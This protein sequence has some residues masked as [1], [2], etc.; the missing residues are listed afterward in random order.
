MGHIG[1]GKQETA[2]KEV[3]RWW[4]PRGNTQKGVPRCGGG[5]QD[6]EEY[7]EGDPQGVY[8]DEFDSDCLPFPS[9]S[10]LSDSFSASKMG[11]DV[12]DTVCCIKAKYISFVVAL[13]FILLHIADVIYSV[14]I[15]GDWF[16]SISFVVNIIAYIGIILG[17]C[18]TMH[19]FLWIAKVVNYVYFLV[20]IS[21]FVAGIVFI[22]L[23]EFTRIRILR[24]LYLMRPSLRG[25]MYTFNVTP[26]DVG[27]FVGIVLI[28]NLIL[29]IILS[30]WTVIVNKSI[31]GLKED[32]RCRPSKEKTDKKKQMPS[33]EQPPSS[34]EKGQTKSQEA[35]QA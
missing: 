30:L 23:S 15:Y 18:L 24:W 19:Y 31:V 10:F 3:L 20:Y 8:P 13:I 16:V 2:Q 22:F 5:V 21:Y 34:E 4:H 32:R 28:Y 7:S 27:W 17:V 35:S 6:E 14:I 29:M 1:R 12:K 25:L 9:D 33:S 11:S 26:F